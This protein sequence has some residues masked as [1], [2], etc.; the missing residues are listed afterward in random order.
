MGIEKVTGGRVARKR[1]A[2]I[3]S[4][5]KTAARLFAQRGYH[6][7]SVEDIAGELDLQKGSLYHYF[8]SKDALLNNIVKQQL[9]TAVNMIGEILAVPEA[10]REKFKRA[11][12]AH[13]H[14]FNQHADIYSIFKFE[15]LNLIDP[16]LADTVDKLS[17]QYEKAWRQLL[18]LG[19]DAGDFRPEID[20]PLLV[21]G[22][23]GILNSTLTWFRP[24][25]R[26]TLD[27]V[28]DQFVELMLG[29]IRVEK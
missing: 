24:G 2:R 9:N 27:D 29:G 7:T 14:L 10:P 3:D 18:Q 19:I 28:A 16:E 12:R 13:L 5:L 17:R 25:G 4:I 26:L 20:V 11:V 21:K 23:E 1:Q 6:A 8:P 15:N 22:F